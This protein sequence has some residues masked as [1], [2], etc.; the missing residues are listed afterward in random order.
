MAV[1]R[2]RPPILSPAA[3]ALGRRTRCARRPGTVCSVR[4]NGENRTLELWG[5]RAAMAV[6]IAGVV[7]CVVLAALDHPHRAVLC[8]VVVLGLMALL[9]LIVPGRPWFASRNRWLD[10]AVLAGIGAAIWYLSPFT[11][12]IGVS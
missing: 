5:G 11:A 2:N 9:R 7:A 10:A 1:S 12:T 4:D 3:A 6:T 8:L